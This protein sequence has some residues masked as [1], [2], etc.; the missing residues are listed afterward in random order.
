MTGFYGALM[1]NAIVQGRQV[2]NIRREY[3][4]PTNIVPGSI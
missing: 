1:R 4:N 3:Y 2:E